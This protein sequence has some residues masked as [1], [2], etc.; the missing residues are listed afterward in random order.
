MSGQEMPLERDAP[1]APTQGE[2]YEKLAFNF[3]KA[4]TI[5]LITGRYALLVASG[6]ATVLYLLAFRHG[7]HDTRCVLR[8]PL[9]SAGF[10]GIVCLL[11]LY[12]T[13]RPHL[14]LP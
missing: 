3:C 14:Q 12:V 5:V 13:L 11:S 4:A 7:K 6:A 1:P 2:A 10:W 9:I 8:H